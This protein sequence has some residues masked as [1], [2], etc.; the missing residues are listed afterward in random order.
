MMIE[1]KNLL[2]N[3]SMMLVPKKNAELNLQII[4]DSVPCPNDQI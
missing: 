4:D 1:P 3:K 2:K